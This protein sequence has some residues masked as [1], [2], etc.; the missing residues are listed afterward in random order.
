LNPKHYCDKILSVK[1]R[2]YYVKKYSLMRMT[3][4]GEIMRTDILGVGFDNITMDEALDRSEE[5][6]KTAKGAY[7]ITPNPEIVWIC[8]KDAQLKE[9]AEKAALVLADGI[10][11]IYGGKILKRPLKEKVSGADYA[12]KLLERMAKTGGKVFF[13]GSKPGVAEVAAENM[14]A[15]YPGLTVCGTADGYFT[16]DA[17]IVEKINAASP[18]FL[19]VCLGAPKQEIWMKKNAAALNVPLMAGLG[20]TLDVFAGT[21]QRAPESWRKLNLEW[22]YRLV[23]Q[24]KRFWRM[25]KLPAFMIA[26][27]W[28]RVRGK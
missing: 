19:M 3:Y 20:G 17:P 14:T 28:Q 12:E 9:A 13:F 27:V 1:L 10:G 26:V 16:E 11:V 24:P 21:V 23:K 8:R 22:L 6:M 2:L 25:M 5:L 4:G 7:V 15:K 18:D